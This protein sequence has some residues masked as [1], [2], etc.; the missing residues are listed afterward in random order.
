M[1]SVPSP[2][3]PPL[4]FSDVNIQCPVTMVM[5]VKTLQYWLRSV[6]DGDHSRSGALRYLLGFVSVSSPGPVA[7]FFWV[8]GIDRSI[9]ISGVVSCLR[10]VGIEFF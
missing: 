4:N 10:W 5:F 1:L 6:V 7:M 2:L 9:W 3:P 8:P